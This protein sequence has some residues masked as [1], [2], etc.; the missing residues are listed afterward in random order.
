MS[1]STGFTHKDR[2]WLFQGQVNLLKRNDYDNSHHA[3]RKHSAINSDVTSGFSQGE[4]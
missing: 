4:T 2:K 1:K 3:V